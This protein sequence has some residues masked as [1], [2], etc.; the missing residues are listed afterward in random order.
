M[1]LIDSLINECDIALKTLSYKKN[2]TGRLYPGKRGTENLSKKEKGLSAQLM[3]INL[4]GEV[5]AQA[6]YRGQA[7]VCKDAEIKEHLIQAGE[8]ETDHLIWCRKRLEDLNGNPS[9]LNPLWYAGSFA[10][11]AI[12]GSL[13]EKTSLGF[14][15]ETE[16]QVVKHLEKHLDQIS[17]NDIQTIKILEIMR[18]DEDEHAKEASNEG[19]EELPAYSKKIMELTAKLMTSSSRYI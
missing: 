4:A 13:G 2:G 14:V 10:I 19:A 7:M 6:L 15:E 8:E 17:K 5:S 16:K 11:G 9:I 1:N 18:A 3:R 12:S